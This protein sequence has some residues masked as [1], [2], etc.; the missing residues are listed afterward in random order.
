MLSC[1]NYLMFRARF[2]RM[3]GT[4][5]QRTWTPDEV[6]ASVSDSRKLG[7]V[8]SASGGITRLA[9][10][11]L[12]DAGIQL[13]PLLSRAGVT[14]EQIEDRGARIKVRSQIKFLELAAQALQDEFLGF[15]LAR[16]YDLREIGLLY[17]V[18]ASSEVLGDSLRRAERYCRIVNEGVALRFPAGN[19]L[20]VTFDYVG[21]SGTLI[22][23][24]SNS[25]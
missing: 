6:S 25:G 1:A 9:C 10:A 22:G 16:D 4:D 5:H 12:R 23:I 11:R 13:A 7:T 14:E 17:Y 24:R 19:E 20:V 21:V 3:Q 2:G 18:L 15:H 8:P